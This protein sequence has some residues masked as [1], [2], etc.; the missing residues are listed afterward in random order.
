MKKMMPWILAAALAPWG[1]G[2][3]PEPESDSAAGQDAAE[4]GHAEE[5]LVLLS[6][7]AVERTGLRWEEARAGVLPASLDTTG[8]VDF[9]QDALAH[10]SP[11]LAGRVDSAPA[12][13]GDRVRRGELLARVDSIEL[14]RAKAEYLQARAR[15]ELA[16]EN[17]ERET[18]LFADRITSEQEMLSARAAHREAVA[19]LETADETLRLYGLSAADVASLAHG[20]PQASIYEL[21]APFDGKVV[22]KHVTVG[23]LVTPESRLFLIADLRTVWVWIDVFEQTLADVH[24]GDGV[25]V[26]V[27]AYPDAVFRGEVSYLSDRVDTDTRTVRARIDVENADERLRPGMFAKIE[28]TDPHREPGAPDESGVA[29]VPE[30]AVQRMGE[31]DVVFVVAGEGRFERRA[32]RAGRRSGGQVE[33]LEGLRAGEPVVTAG[34]FRLKSEAAKGSLDAE[35]GH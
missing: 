10:A 25:R 15:A 13:L 26:R 33:I 12:R 4:D 18:A 19:A 32:V 22:E 27:D 30:D 20:D 21:R 8:A 35:H 16:K 34:A 5:G 3:A 31:D 23:E 9:D 11:R 6:A 24:L 2:G 29:L 14:G 28:L 17:Y 1:C 7:E